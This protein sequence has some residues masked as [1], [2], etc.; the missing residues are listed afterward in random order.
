MRLVSTD[1]CGVL[2]AAMAI[3][4][5]LGCG[6]AGT[7]SSEGKKPPAPVRTTAHRLL[8]EMF[9]AYRDA[10][11]Y[12]DN[13]LYRERWVL[14]Q[15]G[16]IQEPPPQMV[17]VTF[18]RPAKL[19]V[20]RR[21][22]DTEGNVAEEATLVSTGSRIYYTLPQYPRQVLETVAP[23]TLSAD[24]IAAAPQVADGLMFLPLEDCF[25][26]LDLL[27]AEKPQDEALVEGGEPTLLDEAL[28]GDRPCH[29]VAISTNAGQRVYWIDKESHLLR[30]LD[31]PPGAVRQTIDPHDQLQDF[32][33]WIELADAMIDQDLPE[34]AF[35]LAV[36]EDAV[37][38]REWV[39]GHPGP[40]P[41]GAEI[42]DQER[43]LYAV[44]LGQYEAGLA[45]AAAGGQEFH[46]EV[47]A[48]E[49]APK[50]EPQLLRITQT[51]QAE[52]V[53]QPGDVIVVSDAGGTHV[54]AIDD[55]QSVVELDL[56]GRVV[57]RHEL[58]NLEGESVSFLRSYAGKDGRCWFAVSGPGRSRV[59]LFDAQWQYQW[60]FPQEENPGIGDVTFAPFG[61]AGQGQ[62]VVGFWGD[63]GVHGV[64]LAGERAWVD[65]SLQQATALVLAADEDQNPVV[66]S[67][68]GRDVLGRVSK[69]SG[70]PPVYVP[71][72]MI[73][74][75]AAEDVSG[76]GQLD[77]CGI[78]FL[79]LGVYDVVGLEATGRERW[80][81]SLPKGEFR[82]PTRRIVAAKGEPLG[83]WVL[84]A[85]DGSI[86]FLS[87]DG[88]PIDSFHY[89]EPITGIAV[90]QHEGASLLVVASTDKLAARRVESKT[91]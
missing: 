9:A 11:T 84:P 73:V 1:T 87:A 6:D 70:L 42:T 50:S 40:P 21:V 44:R 25:P 66:W 52:G 19:R 38:V 77:V 86:H 37:V 29:R 7:P 10:N 55:G 56:S 61:E 78:A 91:E 36:P 49:I 15:D 57:A 27:L 60:S 85:A 63:I 69:E 83:G 48:P 34:E 22:P 89:G 41:E 51:W 5:T 18:E 26:Q 76:D 28:L 79:E 3:V 12:A 17:S 81:Y 74:D 30:R 54:F 90:A 39:S 72:R 23:T 4:C 14:R 88:K 58:P 65:R 32:Q 62:V 33:R 64:S 71:S 53:T 46:V 45:A 8:D 24:D 31:L 59:H 20:T 13:G 82:T 47:A 68:H 43:N 2:A 16:V 35:A 80:N 75:L 67:A